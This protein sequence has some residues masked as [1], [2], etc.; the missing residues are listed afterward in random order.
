MKADAS[1]LALLRKY[2]EQRV[3]KRKEAH[4]RAYYEARHRLPD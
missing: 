1:D 4:W 3:S 2:F